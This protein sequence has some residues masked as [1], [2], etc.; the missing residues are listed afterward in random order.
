MSLKV[1]GHR[2]DGVS[3]KTPELRELRRHQGKF[4]ENTIEAFKKVLAEGADGI[5]FDVIMSADDRVMVIH[6]DEIEKHALNGHGRVKKKTCKELKEFDVG[7][8]FKIPTLEET[9]E[10]CGKKAIMNIELKGPATA[11]PTMKI[12]AKYIKKGWK[13][14][15]FFISSFDRN[16]IDDALRF[17]PEIRTGILFDKRE[18]IS[19][20]PELIKKYRPFSIHPNAADVTE[21]MLKA[22][23]AYGLVAFPWTS[24]EKLI[25]S[26]LDPAVQ[27]L[28]DFS[29]KDYDIWLI[30]DYPKEV[31][32][33]LNK[34]A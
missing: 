6:D 13:K 26:R 28:V 24:G 17:D 3:N 5:E 16:L 22:A 23:K 7:N 21:E 27:R 34:K 9:I 8:G 12:V 33:A 29:K 15:N 31:I 4:P 10:A 20:I 14:E 30:T 11:V 18:K 1:L 25:E 19:S 32:R 2:G